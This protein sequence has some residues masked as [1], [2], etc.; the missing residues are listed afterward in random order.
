VV[1]PVLV[2]GSLI[3]MVMFGAVATNFPARTSVAY[4]PVTI[5]ANYLVRV[6]DKS[7]WKE[8]VQA[9]EVG[10]LKGA[11]KLVRQAVYEEIV[12][13]VKNSGLRDPAVTGFKVSYKR[14]SWYRVVDDDVVVKDHY[15]KHGRWYTVKKVIHKTTSVLI[16]GGKIE[17]YFTVNALAQV[18][19]S[20]GRVLVDL[21]WRNLHLLNGK[22]VCFEDDY[23]NYISTE[24][25]EAFKWKTSD[26]T[27]WELLNE[28]AGLVLKWSKNGSISIDWGRLS[29]AHDVAGSADTLRKVELT[30]QL[31][32]NHAIS[33][34]VNENEVVILAKT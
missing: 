29:S 21:A 18:N 14:M 25:D 16:H 13:A 17:F 30:I 27:E 6:D 22:I 5:H 23:G 33:H 28:T 3:V 20:D 11:D 10:R 7:M 2:V 1:A 34:E 26:L 19:K 8:V 24:I 9:L 31:P 15:Y 4:V 32:E 12:E